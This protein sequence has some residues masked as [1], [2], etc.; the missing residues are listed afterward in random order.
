MCGSDEIH[1]YS[2]RRFTHQKQQVR[3]DEVQM[4]IVYSISTQHIAK[5]SVPRRRST[6]ME[7]RFRFSSLLH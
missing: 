7:K 1:P 2:V 3:V 5:L 4:E 6:K